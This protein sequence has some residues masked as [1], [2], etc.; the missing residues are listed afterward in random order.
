M[1]TLTNDQWQSILA[2]LKMVAE[3]AAEDGAELTVDSENKLIAV[4]E[5]QLA[6]PSTDDYVQFTRLLAAIH[7]GEGAFKELC[8]SMEIF[9]RA[10]RAWEAIKPPP[11]NFAQQMQAYFEEELDTADIL[12]KLDPDTAGV[13]L[14]E[15]VSELMSTPQ[16]GV[17]KR[18]HV[19]TVNHK[20]HWLCADCAREHDS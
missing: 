12:E 16:C 6:D 2:S 5:G 8:E 10:T 1:P 4:I 18:L 9:A 11:L 15:L 14:I 7:I 13:D 19:N 3:T 20:G 17:C